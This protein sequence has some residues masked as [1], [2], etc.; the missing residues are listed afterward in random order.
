MNIEA[1]QLQ[2]SLSGPNPPLLVDVRQPQELQMFGAIAGSLLIPMNELPAR[3]AELPRDRE[4]VLYCKSGMRSGNA[5][6]WLRQQGW[7]AAN[8]AGG[9][10]QWRLAGLPVK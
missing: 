3:L 5:A 9:I 4:I 6:A 7:K 2:Q 8:L 10:D 1:R